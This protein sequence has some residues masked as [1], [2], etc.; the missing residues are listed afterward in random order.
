MQQ[1]DFQQVMALLRSPA[2]QQLL[3][4]LKKNGGSA[5][6]SAAAQASAGDLSGAQKTISPLLEN[7]EIRALLR[8]LGGNP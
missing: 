6:Q 5:A 2:G 7:P 1:P 3:E 8:Q 4:Y